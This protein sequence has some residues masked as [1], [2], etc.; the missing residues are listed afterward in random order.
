MINKKKIFSSLEACSSNT[1][2]ANNP[3][4]CMFDGNEKDINGSS[5]TATEIMSSSDQKPDNINAYTYA[6][7]PN[8]SQ[9]AV[10]DESTR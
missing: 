9:E 5:N 8:E 1:S 10:T 2:L 7:S 4:S 3:N 6:G